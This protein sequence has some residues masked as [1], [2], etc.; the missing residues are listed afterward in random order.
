MSNVRPPQYTQHPA[1]TNNPPGGYQQLYG[2]PL[3]DY[4]AAGTR[5]HAAPFTA[6]IAAPVDAEELDDGVTGSK[7]GYVTPKIPRE[8]MQVSLS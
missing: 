1:V 8:Y 6:Q 7:Q 4:S 2:Q 3:P 5:R